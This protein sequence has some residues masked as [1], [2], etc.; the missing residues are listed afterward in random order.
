MTKGMPVFGQPINQLVAN[1]A[2]LHE[3]TIQQAPT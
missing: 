3:Q 1:F 2:G